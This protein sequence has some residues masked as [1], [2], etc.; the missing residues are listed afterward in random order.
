MGGR[1]VAP[2]VDI[3]GASA[4]LP[5]VSVVPVVRIRKGRKALMKRSQRACYRRPKTGQWEIPVSE[6]GASKSEKPGGLRASDRIGGM[7]CSWHS[8]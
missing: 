4:S 1:V 2:N 7:P 8:Y 5:A 3:V 6:G